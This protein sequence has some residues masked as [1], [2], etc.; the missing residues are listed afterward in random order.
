[1]GKSF[2]GLVSIINCLPP[3]YEITAQIGYHDAIKYPLYNVKNVFDFLSNEDYLRV[4]KESDIVAGHA[5]VGFISDCLR[6]GKMPAVMARLS[7]Y[8]EHN[9]DHQTDFV[10]RYK[11]D[12]IFAVLT[13]ELDSKKVVAMLE[14]VSETKPDRSY[15]TDLS[16]IKKKI[17]NDINSFLK[18]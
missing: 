5:G 11:H 16:K 13:R 6:H 14:D 3:Y 18:K 2:P 17:K 1:M 10:S 8:G 9:N 7:R 15:I 12:N 4:L